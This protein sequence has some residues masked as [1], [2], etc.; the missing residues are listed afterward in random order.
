[1]GTAASDPTKPQGAPPTRVDL[2]VDDDPSTV[3]LP[4][5]TRNQAIAATAPP[6]DEH[7]VALPL[8]Y[9]LH[10]YTIK[11][12]LGSGSFGIT[13]LAHDANLNCLVAIK[14]YFPEH[15]AAR[16]AE[17]AVGPATEA[18]QQEY[19]QGLQRF[20]GETRV[21]ASF[22]HR[23]IVRVT[24]FFEANHTAYMVMDYEKGQPLREW[25]KGRGPLDEQSLLRMFIPLLNGLEVVH[26]AGVLHRDIKPGNIYVREEDSSLVLL[27]FGAA[28]QVVGGTTNSMTS[29]VTPG[30]APLEQYHTKGA[31]GPWSDLYAMGG[32]LYWLA[33]GQR[34]LEAPARVR[35]DAMPSA[36]SL[37]GERFSRNFL[38]AIDWALNPDE[39]QR[40][41]NVA[42]F[43]KALLGQDAP[44]EVPLT[45]AAPAPRWGR[46]HKLAAGAA[47]LLL[48]GLV[49]LI[50]WSVVQG[51]YSEP[52]PLVSSPA[53]VGKMPAPAVSS[54]ENGNGAR[55]TSAKQASLILDVRPR[56]TVFIDGKKVGTSP[57]LKTLS[58]S[59]GK[60]LVAIHGDQYPG[61]H[62]F[63]L[64]LAPN[65]KR[66]IEAVFSSPM[67]P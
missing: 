60:H 1:M 36:E 14:E 52:L 25:L 55:D 33:T 58:V 31:L 42:E 62:Y 16:R 10:E 44:L 64:E 48:L 18:D 26:R 56:G 5:A 46:K 6:G 4:E 22:R 45:L 50:G 30:Y 40:P 27:D 51:K 19:W 65:E 57:P 8:G 67:V 12:A 59:A 21:L 34:P 61:V 11:A 43:K 47:L 3:I 20:L 63:R 2:L 37:A 38:C 41:K 35:E 15:L 7:Y 29:I 17:Q 66:R 49:G 28:R 39:Q 54:P 23:N 24:R 9:S 32:V 53:P 13:Y